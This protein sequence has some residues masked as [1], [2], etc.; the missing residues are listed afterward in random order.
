[1]T[2]TQIVEVPAN[3]RVTI[4]I[5]SD[6]PVG[7]TRLVIQFPFQ[8]DTQI[9]TVSMDA[10][11]QLSNEAFRQALRSA[12]GAWKDNPWTNHLDDVNSIRNE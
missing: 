3:R 2:I 1:M 8:G 6:I 7:S 10:K 11:G 5:P 4:E 12:H 9:D